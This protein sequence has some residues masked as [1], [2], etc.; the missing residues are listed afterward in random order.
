MIQQKKINNFIK[1]ITDTAAEKREAVGA[2]TE[3]ILRAERAEL[4]RQAKR[5]AEN[6]VRAKSASVK[7]EAGKRISEKADE[8]RKAVFSKRSEIADA[9]LSEAAEKL[10]AFT[11]SPEYKDFLIKSAGEVLKEIGSGNV[12][13]M[14]RPRDMAFKDEI[15]NTYPNASVSQ[16][17]SIRIGGV[18]G[19][20]STMT[21][22]INDTL[23]SRLE[24][25]KRWFEEN[26]GL[27]ISMR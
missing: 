4:E 2:E 24:N 7:L 25:Q 23:D 22:L 17:E 6:Y 18:K 1:S 13:L 21:L 14:L 27:Y 10:K 16:D 8:C 26:S 20:N 3:K 19:I 12:T 15:C 9:T 5:D 11:E